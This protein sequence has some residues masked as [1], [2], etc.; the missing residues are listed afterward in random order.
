MTPTTSS[1]DS[2][3]VELGD[4]SASYSITQS[5]V[6]LDVGDS[7]GSVPTFNAGYTIDP[8]ADDSVYAIGADLT[9]T[10]PDEGKFVGRVVSVGTP[11]PNLM[12]LNAETFF[13]NLTVDERTYPIYRST[14]VGRYGV[15]AAVDH[16][17][18][19]AGLFYD[20]V[21][22][23]VHVY[24]SCF[25]HDYM[26]AFDD[27]EKPR[28]LMVNAAGVPQMRYLTR[29]G[30]VLMELTPNTTCEALPSSSDEMA[31]HKTPVPSYTSGE[32]LVMSVGLSVGGNHSGHIRWKFRTDPKQ[33]NVKLPVVHMTWEKGGIEVS[34]TNSNNML[35]DVAVHRTTLAEGNYRVSIGVRE[36]GDTTSSIRVN[37]VNET[38][39]DVT[40]YNTT[41][42]TPLR[43]TQLD[44]RS[45]VVVPYDAPEGNSW[46]LYGYFVATCA[47]VP[48]KPLAAQKA[49][50]MTTETVNVIPGF[51]GDVWSR[52]KML[53]SLHRMD[54][55]YLDNKLHTGIRQTAIRTLLEQSSA[56]LSVNERETARH[57][58][59]VN[60]RMSAHSG[61]PR[62]MYKSD[63]VQQVA[64]GETEVITV[65]TEHSIDEVSDPVCVSGITPFPYVRGTGQ[66]VITG[67]DGYIVSPEWWEDNG[68]KITARTTSQEGEIEITI[69]GPDFDSPRAPYRVSEGD[70]GRPAL[71]ITGTGIV[72]NPITLKIPT[73]NPE[74]SQDVGES[75]DIP[76][77]TDARMAYDA[78]AQVSQKYAAPEVTF[79][80]TEPKYEGLT[81]QLSKRGTGALLKHKGNVFRV[82]TVTSN[83]AT[84]QASGAVQY[85]T[86]A[87]TNE[88]TDGRTI[89]QSNSA[90]D[91]RSIKHVALKPLLGHNKLDF[92]NP[93]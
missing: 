26:Y 1:I 90:R 63:S 92:V 88:A 32:W 51:N 3:I 60:Q 57:I 78:A 7:A 4:Q 50:G 35:Q 65:Q 85:N 48:D 36:A 6:P 12:N 18:Q 91:S 81:S 55:W 59:V 33:G 15:S 72:A 19:A 29:A 5:A 89:A 31:S 44:L 75:V 58:E 21:P 28:L 8:D 24:H 45:M 71:Y 79:S 82:A 64:T 9:M 66:Y 13:T 80:V 77:I 62:V 2:D 10:T 86:I 47:E 23:R 30:R 17:T 84:N 40:A 16:W 69:K 73:G 27:L 76:F 41:L 93:F 14:G 22:G 49:L 43:G 87:W 25:G 53:L 70:A 54:L 67:S 68:G 42:A 34:V 74:A 52:L 56:S 38:T 61:V 83:R 46:A 37:L 39:G 11:V 20:A